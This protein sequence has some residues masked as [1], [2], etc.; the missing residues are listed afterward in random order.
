MSFKMRNTRAVGLAASTVLLASSLAACGGSGGGAGD[1]PNTLTVSYSQV[2]GDELPIWIADDAGLFKKQGLNVK[3][4]SLSSDQGFP[5]LISGQTQMASIGGSEM[6][7]GAASGAKVKY[8]ATLTPVFPYKLYTKLSS[9]GALKGKKIGI[10][11]ASGSLYIATLAALKQLG[12]SAKDVNLVPLGSVTNVNNALIAG[13]IDAALS[14][15][16]A[17][18]KFEAEGFHSLLDLA[19][20]KIPTS[21]VGIAATSSYVSAHPK[22]VQKFMNALAEGIQREKS[23]KAYAIQELSKHL[24]TTDKAALE[25]TYEYYAN[26]V[27][28]DVPVPTVEQLATSQQA[29]SG[30]VKGV[31]GLDL[32]SLVD[33]DFVAK[34]KA[35]ATPA[36]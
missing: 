17:T 3:L 6:V 16:P 23:D 27:L 4:V 28:P 24:G 36:G 31:D 9:A 30:T 7:S 8:L 35:A 11:S 25:E 34:A 29:L 18:S 10:T 2:V 22:Q 26:E 32:S 20:Q 12:L 5:A 21:N 14:H 13:S 15:P 1:D 33:G 19:K